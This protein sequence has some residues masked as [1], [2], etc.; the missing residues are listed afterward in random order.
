[1]TGDNPTLW[2]P[3]EETK[4]ILRDLRAKPRGFRRPGDAPPLVP[5][6]VVRAGAEAGTSPQTYHTGRIRLLPG[7]DPGTHADVGTA[8]V[9]LADL[10]GGSLEEDKDYIALPGGEHEGLPLYWCHA[11]GGGRTAYRDPHTGGILDGVDI[12]ESNLGA[13]GN[14]HIDLGAEDA[15]AILAIPPGAGKVVV[16]GSVVVRIETA[17]TPNEFAVLARA[18]AYATAKLVRVDD[19]GAYTSDLT[20][21][22]KAVAGQVLFISNALAGGISEYF[23]SGDWLGG[24]GVVGGNAVWEGQAVARQVIDRLPDDYLFVSWR[25]TGT[26][27]VVNGAIGGTSTELYAQQYG[28]GGSGLWYEEAD[29][30]ETV[31]PP[32]PPP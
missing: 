27:G 11:G 29:V 15:D 20:D 17:M 30:V 22:V 12:G 5:G 32:P 7:L 21:P 28:D 10:D 14:Y 19:E 6:S 23:Y 4:R 3:S 8:D 25:I 24:V 16:Y 9:Y 1:M 26:V 13:I 31:I 2:Q 18:H